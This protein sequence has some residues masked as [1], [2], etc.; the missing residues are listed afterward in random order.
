MVLLKKSGLDILKGIPHL[1]ER[2]FFLAVGK[3]TMDKACN[4]RKDRVLFSF[5]VFSVVA[6]YAR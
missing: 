1:R 3:E 5:L 6:R 2:N 4:Y